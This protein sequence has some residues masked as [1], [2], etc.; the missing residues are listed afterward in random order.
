MSDKILS[1]AEGDVEAVN[2][3]TCGILVLIN[4]SS[5][6][7]LVNKQQIHHAG[8]DVSLDRSF[9]RQ[10]GREVDDGRRPDQIGDGGAC[11]CA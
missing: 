7:L 8:N 4:L 2:K 11:L 9:R 1:L 6:V 10:G 3:I 5:F